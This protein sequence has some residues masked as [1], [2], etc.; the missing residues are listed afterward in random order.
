MGTSRFTQHGPG[1]GKPTRRPVRAEEEAWK[2]LLAERKAPAEGRGTPK[3]IMRRPVN[4]PPMVNIKD[5]G[6]PE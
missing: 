6:E 5:G 3:N 1:G 4:L 2:E